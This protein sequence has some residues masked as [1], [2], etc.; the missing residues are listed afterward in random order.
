MKFTLHGLFTIIV[1]AFL[2]LLL[3][4][5]IKAARIQDSEILPTGPVSLESTV[6]SNVFPVVINPR[7]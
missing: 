6:N 3:G 2:L 7:S 5:I 4:F 1:L